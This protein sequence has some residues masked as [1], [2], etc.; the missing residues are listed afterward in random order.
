MKYSG[1]ENSKRIWFSLRQYAE[2]AR[3]KTMSQQRLFPCTVFNNPTRSVMEMKRAS[4]C[5]RYLLGGRGFIVLGLH[6]KQ[7]WLHA[8]QCCNTHKHHKH[9]PSRLH[10]QSIVANIYSRVQCSETFTQNVRAKC[11][12]I[13]SASSFNL[14]I[15]YNE[16]GF[17][18]K[19]QSSL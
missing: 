17:C 3:E 4:V 12:T 1:W 7:L 8:L 16:A 6:L 11:Q 9:S 2:E 5:E 14:L 18:S 10:S 15:S 13:Q 19:K